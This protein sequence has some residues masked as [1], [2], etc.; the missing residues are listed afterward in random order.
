MCRVFFCFFLFVV[1]VLLV[2][3]TFIGHRCKT[4]S[5]IG[6]V[7]VSRADHLILDNQPIKERI[8]RKVQFSLAWQLISLFV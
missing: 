6:H 2:S 4:L 3:L 8:S 5:L 7:Q 1:V